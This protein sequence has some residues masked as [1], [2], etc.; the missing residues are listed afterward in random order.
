MQQDS[1][2]RVLE[3]WQQER[4]DLDMAPIGIVGRLYRLGRLVEDFYLESTRPY[5]L[6]PGDFFVLSELRRAGAPYLLS[7]SQLCRVL[8]LSSGGMTKQ[9]DRLE[10]AGW[11]D[12]EPDPADRRGRKVRLTNAGLALIDEALK[13][14]IDNEHLLL[15]EVSLA[16]RD[17]VTASLR[18]LIQEFEFWLRVNGAQ[19][20]PRISG[21]Q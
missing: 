9:L 4:P 10:V 20:S 3:E 18:K 21:M 2:D 7:P 12:R 6:K 1:F 15:G 11:I 17:E 5:G 19:D 16:Q 8:V 13:E 14:H